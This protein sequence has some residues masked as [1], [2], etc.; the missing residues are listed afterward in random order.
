MI[1]M[2]A[3]V[4]TGNQENPAREYKDGYAVETSYIEVD[5]DPVRLELWDVSSEC[6]FL[7][8]QDHCRPLTTAN[9]D[10]IVVCFDIADNETLK[11]ATAK[12]RRGWLSARLSRD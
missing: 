6:N 9:Y 3:D 8:A 4:S 12:V 5:S 11:S 10:L 2:Q 1:E 7:T